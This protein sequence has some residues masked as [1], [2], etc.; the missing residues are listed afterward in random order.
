MNMSVEV[1]EEVVDQRTDIG[2]EKSLAV[3][4]D[5]PMTDFQETLKIAEVFVKSGFFKDSVKVSQAAVK[6]MAGHEY[7][8]GPFASMNGIYIVKEKAALSANLMATAIKRSGKYNYRIV[9]HTDQKCA[10]DFYER[11]KLLGR[12]EFSRD[13]AKRAGTQNMEKFP[14]NMLFARALSNGAKWHCPDAFGGA[15]VYAPDELGMTQREDGSFE[16]PAEELHIAEPRRKSEAANPT[17][18]PGGSKPYRIVKVDDENPV[19]PAEI[20]TQD[21]LTF[22]LLNN[23]LLIPAKSAMQSSAQ[24]ILTFEQTNGIW[25]VTG[26]EEMGV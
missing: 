16:E 19:T 17:P 13:D 15:P 10:I 26:I 14:K 18:A 25:Y 24:T 21:G 5:V 11:G 3:R 7:G 4:H 1:V 22:P 2:P 20:T 23:G 6:I 9:E 8:F 12:S